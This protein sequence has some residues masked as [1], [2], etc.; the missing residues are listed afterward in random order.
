MSALT[1]RQRIV[2]LS[3]AVAYALRQFVEGEGGGNGKGGGGE[4]SVELGGRSGALGLLSD[5]CAH[6]AFVRESGVQGR[7]QEEGQMGK[8]HGWLGEMVLLCREG[9]GWVGGFEEVL[10]RLFGR[11][12][13]VQVPVSASKEGGMGRVGSA[14]EGVLDEVFVCLCEMRAGDM[15]RDVEEEEERERAREAAERERKAAQRRKKKSK[16]KD[17]KA[18][19]RAEQ[20]QIEQ[21][22]ELHRVHAQ[23][24]Q[25]RAAE[26]QKCVEVWS[27]FVLG[28]ERTSNTKQEGE[29]GFH[30]SPLSIAKGVVSEIVADA[31]REIMAR[32]AASAKAARRQRK[33][34]EQQQQQQQQLLSQQQQLLHHQAYASHASSGSSTP[35]TPSQTAHASAP[36]SGGASSI[37]LSLPFSEQDVE[38]TWWASRDALA[39]A[40]AVLNSVSGGEAWDLERERERE[41]IEREF[42]HHQMRDRET[43]M[44]GMSVGAGMLA[45]GMHAT[46]PE[47]YGPVGGG[48]MGPSGGIWG[49]Y[50]YVYGYNHPSHAHMGL[51]GVNPQAHSFQRHVYGHTHSPYT[52]THH[53]HPP[54]GHGHGHMHSHPHPHPHQHPHS[55]SHPSHYSYHSMHHVNGHGYPSPP[56]VHNHSHAM[57]SVGGVGGGHFS[58]AGTPS[59]S[60]G[61]MERE[62]WM[63]GEEGRE[64]R[65]REGGMDRLQ[66]SPPTMRA[67]D[68]N[69]HE[70]PASHNPALSQTLPPSSFS[71]SSAKFASPYNQQLSLYSSLPAKRGGNWDGSG[72]TVWYGG[73]PVFAGP[74]SVDGGGVGQEDDNL[75][76]VASPSRFPSS[77]LGE[78][79]RLREDGRQW[80]EDARSV[81]S[82]DILD[83][84]QHSYDARAGGS[85]DYR[86]VAPGDDVR[87]RSSIDEWRHRSIGEWT[88]GGGDY[89]ARAQDEY[90]ANRLPT[91]AWTTGMVGTGVW[92]DE[93]SS[94]HSTSR[95]LSASSSVVEVEV[96]AGVGAVGNGGSRSQTDSPDVGGVQMFPS[97][98]RVFREREGQ[99]ERERERSVSSL[100]RSGSMG[101]FGGGGGL[102]YYSLRDVQKWNDEGEREGDRDRDRETETRS[103]PG[104]WWGMGEGVFS[105]DEEELDAGGAAVSGECCA[106]QIRCLI[107]ACSTMSL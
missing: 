99:R 84:M 19:K 14:L 29:G 62:M 101:R 67:L 79:E 32:R 81:E 92:D 16:D 43:S 5:L 12:R 18:R 55:H 102:G 6:I 8:E 50:G 23:E 1:N 56:P 107:E 66:W 54:H 10:G 90:H 51:H 42:E 27:R 72:E 70:A 30:D 65:E 35:S 76:H 74:G 58:P 83:G 94:F 3:H 91:H 48:G 31:L 96:G 64:V 69:C 2:R 17:R 87:M 85:D 57:Y 21:M 15:A 11:V 103:E 22:E 45:G 36:T 34:L 7:S 44:R 52:N 59:G 80:E 98:Y 78:D 24:E 95:P 13:G 71:S 73:R 46:S 39:T 49:M 60:F 47:L 25:Q 28:L 53:L 26:L 41:L 88:G 77:D 86:R 61:E 9:D 20:L 33:L 100:R 75:S 37:S 40:A 82:A 4:G 63:F 93:N 38:H 89:G 106:F 68:L 104:D 105:I 97:G